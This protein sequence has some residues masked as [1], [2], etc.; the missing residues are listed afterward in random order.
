MVGG[1]VSNT[2]ESVLEAELPLLPTFSATPAGTEI[3]MEAPAVGVTVAVYVMLSVVLKALTVALVA[4]ISPTTKP[5]TASLKVMVSVNGPVTGL[6]AF[7]EMLTVGT[8]AFT[9][10]SVVLPT[11]FS[12]R[13]ALL[14]GTSVI[15]LPFN[16]RLLICMPSIS[17]C[18]AT[19]VYSK[20]N[21]LVPLV[22]A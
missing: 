2:N 20:F 16:T 15:V 19:T 9:L 10:T 5:V 1:V 12:V 7:D 22:P 17:I 6:V 11:L 14:P 18:P 13:L 3:E 21:P 8:M 4:L